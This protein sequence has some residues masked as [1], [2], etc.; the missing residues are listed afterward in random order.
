MK[1]MRVRKMARRENR[2]EWAPSF[3]PDYPAV[4][5]NTGS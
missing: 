5:K 2:M 3:A 1:T 4:L